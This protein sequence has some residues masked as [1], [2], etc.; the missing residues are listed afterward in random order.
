[1]GFSARQN[2]DIEYSQWLLQNS[3]EKTRFLIG[4]D[5]PSFW[6]TEP[7]FL[8]LPFFFLFPLLPPFDTLFC[9]SMYLL[10]DHP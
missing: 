5:S 2:F 9:A 3:E 7:A 6:I 10:R 1:M 4:S 8:F